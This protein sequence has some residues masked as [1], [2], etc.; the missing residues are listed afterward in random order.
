MEEP[1]KEAK[2]IDKLFI[3]LAKN[4]GSD[5]H[6]K[7]GLK[8]VFRIATVLH[9]VG[10]YPLSAADIKRFIYQIMSDTQTKRFEAENNLDFAYEIEGVGRFRI[11]VFQERG[12][13]AVAV[14]RVNTEIPSFADL[15]LPPV[16]Q[17]IAMMKEGLVVVSGVTGSGKSTT[18][19]SMV[20]YIND[21]RKCHIITIEDPIEYLFKDSKSFIN[22]REIGIDVAS[23]N[24]ALKYIVRQNP[25]V[26]LVGEMRDSESVEAGLMAAETGHLVFGTLHASN[27]TQTVSRMLDLFPAERQELIRQNLALNLKA[28][29]CQKLAPSAKKEVR[30]VPAAE[31][32]LTNSTIQKFIQN[33]EDKKIPDVIK[34]SIDEGMQDFNRSLYQFIKEGLLTEEIALKYSPNA[35]QL[36][37]NLKGISLEEGHKIIS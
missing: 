4:K 23:F 37:M 17:K 24:A 16:I 28:V 33:K 11:N 13:V 34:T 9:E 3:A 21:N 32:M 19:A 1:K 2:E 10:N 8:P 31:V 5:M 35:E 20:Q 22:Q 29:L 26:I 12:T 14:R 25:D 30:V 7:T 27:A 15:H 18:L 36:R 6:L